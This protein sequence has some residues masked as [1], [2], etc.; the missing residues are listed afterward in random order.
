MTATVLVADNDPGVRA[1]LA[2]VVARTGCRVLT[3]ADGLEANAVLDRQRVDVLVCDLDMPRLP[4][5]AVLAHAAGLPRPPLV[6]VVSGFLDGPTMAR[7]RADPAVRA[8]L[9]KPFDVVAFGALV[10][11]LATAPAAGAAAGEM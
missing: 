2:E 1:L 6:V 7:L 4:G 8:M 11:Q 3:A 9:R 5:T 10:R